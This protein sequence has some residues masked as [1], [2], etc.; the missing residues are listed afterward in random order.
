MIR[1]GETE[2]ILISYDLKKRQWQVLMRSEFHLNNMV[3]HDDKLYIASEW[4]YF[5]FN[6][7]TGEVN[8]YKALMQ[9]NGHKLETDINAL[10]FDKQ[11]GMWLG[12]EQRGLL[13]SPPV[14][15]PF[16][17]LP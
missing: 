15:A 10:E 16:K 7:L 12:T 2:A 5:T 6:L 17:V 13:Y 4:G 3:V 14:N 9:R 1:N 8:H 11:G